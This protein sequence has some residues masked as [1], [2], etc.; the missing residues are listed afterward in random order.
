MK[1]I[2]KRISSPYLIL[3]ITIPVAILILFNGIVSQYSKAQGEANLRATQEVIAKSITG[4]DLPSLMSL[5]GNQHLSDSV[6]FLVYNRNGEVSRAFQSQSSFV[7]TEI[8]TLAY[9]ETDDL[10]SNEIGSFRYDGETY[11]VMTVD[12]TTMSYADRLVYIS[13]GLAMDEFANTVN[14]VLLVVSLVI[15]LIALFVSTRV[16]NAVAKPIER[17]T[18]LVERMR[19]DEIL[20]IDDSSDTLELHKLTREIN[21]LNQRIYHYDQSQKNFLHNASH[22]LRTPL[23]SIQGYADGIEMGVFEDA[24]GTAHLISDQSKRLTS[25]VESLLKLARAENFNTNKQLK[26]L[27]LSDTLLALISGYNGYAVGQNIAIQTEIIPDVFADANTELLQGSVGN[28]IANAIRYAK[29]NVTISLVQQGKQAVITVRDDGTGVED[30]DKI[31]DRFSKGDDGNF[32]LGLSIANT[33]IQMMNGTVKVYNDGG[34]VFEITI[35]H[36]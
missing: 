1:P 7:S 25:L 3:I 8:A 2:R 17:L 9:A 33:S 5:V 21:A 12:Y 11:Y 23:M 32:G 31:F 15:T 30:V 4:D 28:I 16:T 24:K 34:A 10:A 13:Q 20:V 35:S 14:L 19:T 36:L 29:S 26:K 6:D 22:E 18:A 27:N